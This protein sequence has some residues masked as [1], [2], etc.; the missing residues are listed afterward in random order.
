MREGELLALKWKNVDLDNKIIHVD[1]SVKT[2]AVFDSDGNKET[3]TLFLEPKTQKSIRDIPLPDVLVNQLKSIKNN[4]E[5]V[6]TNEGKT[7]THKA[8]YLS[9]K[10]NLNKINIPYRKF[11]ALRHTYA[12]TLLSKGADIKTVSELMGHY[13]ISITQI[14]LHSL[15][16]NKKQAVSIW[17]NI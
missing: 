15:P 7:V 12:I 13:D 14:Y 5:F 8:L 16:E 3:K 17:D 1:E 2:V 4:S 6:F 11:H 10:R 9:W